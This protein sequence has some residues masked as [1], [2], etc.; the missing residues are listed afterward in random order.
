M[1]KVIF[2]S[3]AIIDVILVVLGTWRWADH[4]ADDAAWASL[5][6]HQ[7]SAPDTF[8]PAMV[9]GLPEPAQ[10]FFRFAIR[11]E[12]PLYTVTEISMEGEFSLGNKAKPNYLPMRA[13]QILAAPHGFV[14][15]LHAGNGLMRVSGSDVAQDANSWSRF[16]L[17]GL[18]P[19]A[20][21]GGD[22]DHARSAF[23]R[24]IA[25]AVF[26]TPAALLP[27]DNI[28]WES[29]D[30]S[31]VRV[32]VTHRDFEQAVDLSVDADGRLSKVIFQR[33]SD[34][35][36]EKIFQLQPFG[37]Y[38]SEYRDFGGFRLPTRIEAGNFFETDEY[39]AF[40][41]V[42]VTSIRFPSLAGD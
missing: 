6:S 32:I 15:K 13:E 12:T 22:A 1:I 42:H 17:L 31:T 16:W 26:W 8:D 40:F 24:Y 30:E 9:D 4:K 14:W 35:N 37:G 20:R 25:E 36:T 41:K 2:I 10:R 19:V 23:G 33:W 11:P 7:P 28:R 34:A 21:A 5:A 18:A 3:L 39:F 29:I 38:L 27:D